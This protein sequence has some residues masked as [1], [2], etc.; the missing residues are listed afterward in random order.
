MTHEVKGKVEA[1]VQYIKGDGLYGELFADWSAL[2]DPTREWCTE[3]ARWCTEAA[4]G[5]PRGPVSASTVPPA[6]CFGCASRS[7]P[8]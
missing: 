2:E 6:R 3:A 8:M 7:S 5:A 1:G 4:N